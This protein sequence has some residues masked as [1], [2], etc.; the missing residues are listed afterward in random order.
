MPKIIEDL[1]G[2]LIAEAK[3]Q[4][5]QNGYDAVT[6]RSIAKGCGV[7]IGTVYN[8]FPSKDVLIATHLLE[9]WKGCI[10][11]I[12]TAASVGDDPQP[13]VRCI[14]DQLTGFASRHSMIFR[15]EA[16]AAGFAGSF[17][18]Y[19]SLLR[20]QIAAP[21][22]RFCSDAFTAQFLAE[23]LLTWS[24]AGKSFEDIYNLLKKLF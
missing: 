10:H 13:V 16:A 22:T 23:S 20:D 18:R 15:D 6:I 3:K 9:D 14:Y 5:E 17:S 24:M 12:E 21:L 4:I 7:G 11:A 8:Y 19:H 2:T 1:K